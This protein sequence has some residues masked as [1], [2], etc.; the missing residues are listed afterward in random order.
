[1]IDPNIIKRM[2]NPKI[3]IDSD[4]EYHLLLFFNQSGLKEIFTNKNIKNIVDYCFGVEVGL[5][6][7]ARKNRTGTLMENIIE[8]YLH[9]LK[10]NKSIEF[11]KQPTKQK[12]SSLWDINIELDKSNRRFDFAIRNTSSDSI[13]IIETNY[14]SGGGS[15]LKSTAG[16]YQ[17][18]HD[19]LSNQNINLIWITDG[20]G[21]HTSK[22]PLEET[23]I[24]ND[25]VFNLHLVNNGALME[26]LK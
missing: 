1:M 16:E 11:I 23:F 17:Y 18:L 5:D 13:A 10:Y 20:H 21:W 3:K 2:F 26:V 25:Y 14:Y 7:N 15:K 24:H 22:K 4:L 12:L 6:T 9:D 19:L 8:E